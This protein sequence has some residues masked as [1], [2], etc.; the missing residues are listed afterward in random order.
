MW[1][2]PRE[3]ERM[4]KTDMQK[5]ELNQTNSL[6]AKGISVSRPVIK[7]EANQSTEQIPV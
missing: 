5:F 4:T 3:Q 1:N 7:D 6:V 2:F